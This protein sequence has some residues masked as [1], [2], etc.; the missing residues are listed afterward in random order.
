[1]DWVQVSSG[2]GLLTWVVWATL[3]ISSGSPMHHPSHQG[4]NKIIQAMHNGVMAHSLVAWGCDGTDWS[5][6]K[7]KCCAKMADGIVRLLK[8]RNGMHV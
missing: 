5:L 8:W 7:D 2:S 1:M 4:A 3:T 6:L